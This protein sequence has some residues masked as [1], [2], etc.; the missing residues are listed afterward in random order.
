MPRPADFEKTGTLGPVETKRIKVIV[1]A[2]QV[3]GRWTAPEDHNSA[4]RRTLCRCECGNERRIVSRTLL[5]GASQWCHCFRRE[6]AHQPRAAGKIQ[7]YTCRL[8]TRSADS[9]RLRM[10]STRATS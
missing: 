5:S 1:L 2:G 6:V 7:G 10:P 3:F 8:A 9:P 4:D